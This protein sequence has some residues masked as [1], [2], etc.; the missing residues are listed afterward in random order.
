[1]TRVVARKWIEQI[2]HPGFR[3]WYFNLSG[4]NKMG[5]YQNDIDC[6]DQLPFH[7]SCEDVYDE[8]LRRLPAEEYDRF[9]FRLIRASQLEITKS[10]IPAKER[11]TFEEDETK[12][13][14]LEP[15]MKE[16]LAEKKE[17]E[18]WMDFLSKK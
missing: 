14:F 17:K 2:R 16:V 13:R 9:V 5:L 15:Y 10:Y 7:P 18:D 6:L 3:K 11:T 12:G 8:A 1:L 4:W